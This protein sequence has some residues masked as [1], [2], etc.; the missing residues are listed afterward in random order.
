MTN[1]LFKIEVSPDKKNAWLLVYNFKNLTKEMIFDDIIRLNIKKGVIIKNITRLFDTKQTGVKVEIARYQSPFKSVQDSIKWFVDLNI[2]P[3]EKGSKIDYYDL[4]YLKDVKKETR[5]FIMRRGLSGSPGYLIDGTTISTEDT[6]GMFN[7]DRMQNIRLVEESGVITGYATVDGVLTV[8]DRKI[9]VEQNVVIDSDVDFKVGHL[10]TKY[11]DLEIHGNV[12]NR[13]ILD[14]P[15]KIMVKGNLLNC[16]INAGQL[17]VQGKIMQGTNLIKVTTLSAAEIIN[18]KNIYAENC[19]IRGRLSA[20]EIGINDSAI[21]NEITD[22]IVFVKNNLE[23][24][25]V[26]N[27][28]AK[29]TVIVLGVDKEISDRQKQLVA[30]I[31][32]QRKVVRD[33]NIERV[34]VKNELDEL[35]ILERKTALNANQ[36]VLKIQLESDLKMLDEDWAKE[37]KK[38]IELIEAHNNLDAD[39][40]NAAARIIVKEKIYHGTQIFLGLNNSIR[41]QKDYG[42]CKIFAGEDQAL[43]IEAV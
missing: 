30:D 11:A 26:G 16:Q 15:G 43:T 31:K 17:I 32:K 29:H 35:I 33:F 22:S 27:D 4:G 20:S 8:T 21:L 7:S 34:K 40:F 12:G 19:N 28:N 39:N 37:S 24:S 6:S 2:G 41:L 25:V 10:I 14:T 18:R 36:I 3:K 5:I 42:A 1:N 9:S 23:V 38:E 13:Y